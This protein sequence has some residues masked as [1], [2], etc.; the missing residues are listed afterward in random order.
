M[1]AFV[2]QIFCILRDVEFWFVGCCGWG[3]GFGWV[4]GFGFVF[5]LWCF[6]DRLVLLFFDFV[7]VS[8]LCWL[9]L[10]G[11]LVGLLVVW[12]GF[13]FGFV[14]VGWG[15]WVDRFCGFVVFVRCAFITLWLLFVGCFL[16]LVVACVGLGCVCWWFD[17]CLFVLVMV[18]GVG[19]F[20]VDFGVVLCCGWFCIG[21]WFE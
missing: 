8:W 2:A 12:I 4:G 17:C 6:L 10:L 21:G 11:C 1:C 13:W 15:G 5:C 9:M 16:W 7:V 3:W 20:G 19:L 18:C 14:F